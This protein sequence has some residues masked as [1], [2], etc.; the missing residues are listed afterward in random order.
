MRIRLIETKATSFNV[1][2]HAK[3]PR[4]GLPLIGRI[5]ANQGH[6]VKIYVETLAPI[7]WDDLAE[8]DLIGF[9]TTTGTTPPA[10]TMADKL[11]EQGKP[12]V[13]GGAHVTFLADEALEHAD[14][15]VRGEGHAAMTELIDA[16]ENGGDLSDIPGL[17][18]HGPDGHVHNP[19]RPNC[20]NEE[21]AALPW[22]DMTLIEGH[23]GMFTVPIM[24]QWGCPFNCN[25]CSVI[26]MFGRRVRARLVEDVLDELET[27]PPGKDVFFYDDNFVVN[28]R[29]TKELLRGMLKRGV[30]PAWSAQMRAEAIYKDK[31]T[32]EW[33]TELLELMRDT[34]CSWVY[35]GFES[36]NPAALE[37]FN[38]SQTV[39]D[40]QDSIRAFHAYNIPIHGMF[41]LG[42]DS[43]TPETIRT[44]VDFAIDNEIDTVQFLTIVPLPGTEFY[45][46]MKAEDRIISYNWELYDGHRVV[47]EP[48]NMSPYEL[49]MAAFQGM[50]RFY[51]PR[52]AFRLL[53]RNIRHELPFLI[54]L[55]F[56]ERKVRIAIPKVALMALIPKLRLNI[57]T[58]L[59]KAI[60]DSRK[61]M[62]L[63]SVFIIP[64]FRRY[65]YHHTRQ[66]LHLLENQ[67]HI[68]WLRTLTRPRQ[69]SSEMA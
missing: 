33:D 45:E 64:M 42:C 29:R 59:Q 28:K 55:F 7:D 40:I 41:V 19:D 17:S 15:V 54:G 13:F 61:W 2:D 24:T 21:F 34:N 60:D 37:E 32:G 23:E 39:E 16:L 3:L 67:K 57:P 49:Q 47:I 50:L 52:R 10:F 12:V 26:K 65:A 53:L 51:A 56:R 11:R 4:L 66:G 8:A 63:R 6:D 44:T 43:D 22:P 69:R 5:L 36:V 35:C 48:K 62:R 9:S 46:L 58:V 14:Y 31:R 30:T 1:Y 27:V 68:A 38:K 20:P 25:F 18:Y